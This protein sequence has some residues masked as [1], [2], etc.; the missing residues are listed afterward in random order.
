[1]PKFS[2]VLSNYYE[3]GDRNQL[4]RFTLHAYSQPSKSLS[5]RNSLVLDPSEAKAIDDSGI[6]GI[7]NELVGVVGVPG[8]KFSVPNA[9]YANGI[10]CRNCMSVCHQIP[11]WA[12][13]DEEQK[14]K[15]VTK[16]MKWIMAK[17]DQ[18]KKTN[19]PVSEA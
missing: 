16:T 1:M 15:I 6:L 2:D 19:E 12:N 11:Y 9:L 3:S 14:D 10:C 13:L 5:L 17:Y 8:A 4:V 18:W 7:R